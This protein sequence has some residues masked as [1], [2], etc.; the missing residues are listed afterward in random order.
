MF[1]ILSPALNALSPGLGSSRA[2]DA[3]G[4]FT[5]TN[6]VIYSDNLEIHSTMMRLKYTGTVDLHENLSARATTQVL[7]DTPG[8]GEIIHVI[9][10][11]V[12][13]LFEYKVTGTLGEP[14]MEPA[15]DLAKLLLVPLHPLK[16]LENLIPAAN[17]NTPT[18]FTNSPGRR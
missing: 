13:K 12:S 7:R 1:G 14:K 6:G 10:W 18:V 5:M 11:P 16:T 17:T 15:N 2:T 4:K 8:L 3:A 9:S